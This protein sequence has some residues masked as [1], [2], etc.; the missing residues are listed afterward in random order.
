M[1]EQAVEE[2]LRTD[3][4]LAYDELRKDRSQAISAEE[5]RAHLTDVHKRRLAG[6]RG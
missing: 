2:W 6:G 3:V 4:T 5:M 1:R